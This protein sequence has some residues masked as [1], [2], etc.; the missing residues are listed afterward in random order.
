M[1]DSYIILLLISDCLLLFNCIRY[2][3]KSPRKLEADQQ[4]LN[5]IP[6]IYLPRSQ[7]KSQSLFLRVDG[8]QDCLQ[9][10][11]EIPSLPDTRTD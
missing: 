3:T 5:L 10:S 2:H 4:S 6:P 7:E 11:L 1:Q 8:A 9:I